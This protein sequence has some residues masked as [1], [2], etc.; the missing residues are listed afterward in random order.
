NQNNN[1]CPCDCSKLTSPIV[2]TTTRR[3]WRPTW[4]RW[5]KRLFENDDMSSENRYQNLFD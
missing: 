3:F 5:G 1:C 2:T 4:N